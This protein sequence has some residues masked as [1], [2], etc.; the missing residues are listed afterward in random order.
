MN[1]RANINSLDVVYKLL[2]S[3]CLIVSSFA[4]MFFLFSKSS[5]DPKNTLIK[6]MIRPKEQ[7]PPVKVSY[8][9][10]LS[11]LRLTGDVNTSKALK[12]SFPASFIFYIF[13]FLFSEKFLEIEMEYLI[14]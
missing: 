6:M 4:L 5:H 10:Y 1:P 2:G 13:F 3:N 14:T 7:Q 12:K 11:Y 9:G 8:S